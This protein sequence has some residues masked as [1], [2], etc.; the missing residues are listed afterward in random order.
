MIR[1]ASQ[2]STITDSIRIDAYTFIDKTIEL[3]KGWNPVVFNLTDLPI[4]KFKNTNHIT[5]FS[6]YDVDIFV[7]MIKTL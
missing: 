5:I 3:E 1:T 7:C 2:L 6:S 4:N